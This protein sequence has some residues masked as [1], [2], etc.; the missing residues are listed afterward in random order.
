[1]AN[2]SQFEFRL[3]IT[4]LELDVTSGTPSSTNVNYITRTIDVFEIDH[5]NIKYRA[6][7]NANIVLAIPQ[8]FQVLRL[9]KNCSKRLKLFFFLF[10]GLLVSSDGLRYAV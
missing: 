3:K 1:M 7:G 10:V 2:D 6:E 8:R 4:T 9:P 5:T